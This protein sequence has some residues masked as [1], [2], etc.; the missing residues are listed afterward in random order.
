MAHNYNNIKYNKLHNHDDQDDQYDQ[1]DGSEFSDDV[2]LLSLEERNNNKI[3]TNNNA[4]T[5][6]ILLDLNNHND[7]NQK[8]LDNISRNIIRFYLSTVIMISFTFVF[9]ILGYKDY[10][11]TPSDNIIYGSYGHLLFKYYYI[12]NICLY[13]LFIIFSI[14]LILY[15]ICCSKI[16][17]PIR[18]ISF[19]KFIKINLFILNLNILTKILYG[20]FIILL[21]D[22]VNNQTINKIP[23]YY[24]YIIADIIIYMT[25]QIF[26][27][28]IINKINN[29][30]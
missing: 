10:Y 11:D 14:Y 26:Y 19:F 2:P 15:V 25:P 16:S 22:E 8:K 1:D 28:P 30:T 6:S 13:L 27:F 21:S 18:E 3:I 5:D 4:D 29:L 20:T 23:K 24:N 12:I 9:L 17:Q 7:I